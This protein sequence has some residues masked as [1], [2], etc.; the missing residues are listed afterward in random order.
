MYAY[1]S[2]GVLGGM[3][4]VYESHYIFTWRDFI[5][6]SH[7]V[8]HLLP[9][10][11]IWCSVARQPETNRATLISMAAVIV[12]S[13]NYAITSL[14]ESYASVFISVSAENILS[15]LIVLHSCHTMHVHVYTSREI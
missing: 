2:V 9:R 7:H 14:L 1:C 4:A 13:I 3:F 15:M 10:Y 11:H 5:T 8:L 6:N 12:F